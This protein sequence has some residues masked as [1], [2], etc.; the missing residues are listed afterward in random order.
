LIKDI[1]GI[2]VFTFALILF[3]VKFDPILTVLIC[4]G[5]RIALDN[6]KTASRCLL[7]IP[8]LIFDG[9]KALDLAGVFLKI[10][11]VIFGGGYGA[12]PFIKNEVCNIRHWVTT[13]Q[14][15]DGM[16]LGQITPGPVA[17]TATFVGFKVMGIP[18]AIIATVSIFLPSFLMLMLLIKIYRKVGNNKYVISFFGGI[19]SAVVAILLSTGIFFIT[20]NWLNI[21]YGIFGAVALFILLFKRIEPIFLILSGALFSLIIG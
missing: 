12:I 4:G 8:L 21:P 20:I 1:K 9:K 16:A 6:I 5:L 2:I 7:A 18:G 11:A 10:G 3:L 19:K 17:I 14:F 13:K 15:L